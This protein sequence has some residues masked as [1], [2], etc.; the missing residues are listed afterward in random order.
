MLEL[1][2]KSASEFQ[3]KLVIHAIKTPYETRVGF[4]R[5]KLL[6]KPII[7]KASLKKNGL[8]STIFEKDT[9]EAFFVSEDP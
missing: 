7:H 3:A 9:E 4:V 8:A 5:R 6:F 2:P 1:R